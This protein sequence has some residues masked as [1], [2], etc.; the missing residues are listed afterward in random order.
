[1]LYGMNHYC[2][3]LTVRT[4]NNTEVERIQWL[5]SVF[6]LMSFRSPWEKGLLECQCGL[7]LIGLIEAGKPGQVALFWISMLDCVRR[8]WAED[9]HSLPLLSHYGCNIAR[10]FKFQLPQFTH[11]CWTLS[12]NKLFFTYVVFC[13]NVSPQH[14]ES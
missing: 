6:N 13:Q 4:F 10:C 5:I 12:Q 14:Q 1:M 7:S 9:K 2:N 11:Y 3:R 8:K